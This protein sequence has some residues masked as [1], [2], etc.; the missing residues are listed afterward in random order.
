MK[1]KAAGIISLSLALILVFSAVWVNAAEQSAPI[2]EN[3]EI[4]T[5]RE[6]AVEGKLKASSP[7]GSELSFEITTPPSKGEITLLD[8]GSF[9]YTPGQG[10][11]GKDYFG[12]KA[13]D[14]DGRASGEATV[15]IK[16]IKQTCAVSYSDMNGNGAH[17]AA[18]VLAER[19]IF[20]GEQVGGKYV[21]NPNT[22]VTRGEFLAMC[23]KLVDADVLNGVIT[24]GFADDESIPDYL[25]PYVSTALLSGVI[26]GYSEGHKIAVFNGDNSISYP[27]AAVMLN[28]SMSLTNV[29]PKYDSIEV[30]AWAV[31]ACANLSACRISDYVDSQAL[32]RAECAKLLCGAAEILD[33]R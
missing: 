20:V 5:Y 13:Y 12:Y 18:T 22:P 19:G 17:Y 23:M 33:K 27:E 11:K 16:L 3:L 21:F 29:T 1:Y 10:K 4:S 8:D 32:T 7:Y 2:A 15:I 25:K 24:T 6:T 31:Q 28:S 14:G 26:S 9:I 30:P